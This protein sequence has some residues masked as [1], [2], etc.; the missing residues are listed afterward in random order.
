MAAAQPTTFKDL[1]SIIIAGVLNPMVPLLFG[2]ALVF[3][4]WGVTTYIL[5]GAEEA[6][7]QEGRQ[8]MIYGIVGLFVMLSVWGLVN[9][10][11]GTFGFSVIIPQLPT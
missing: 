8:M 10:L 3:F 11:A 1:V 6:K 2:A 5:H 4:L 9:V 7:R